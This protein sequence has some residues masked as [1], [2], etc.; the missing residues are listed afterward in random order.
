MVNYLIMGKF[1]DL[2]IKNVKETIARSERFKE[3]A[4]ECGVTIKEIMWLTGDYDVFS[5]A[6]AEDEK[7]IATLLLKAG[8]RGYVKT[9]SYRAFNKDEV[10]EMVKNLE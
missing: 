5:I 10:T 8:S 3:I 9:N 6:E 7:Q 4:K 2:G 1:T